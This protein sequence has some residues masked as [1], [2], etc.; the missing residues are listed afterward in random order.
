MNSES[1]KAR[2]HIT[3]S[4]AQYSRRRI[5]FRDDCNL[6][7]GRVVTVPVYENI[8][9][10]D[11]DHYSG[12]EGDCHIVG[13]QNL[14]RKCDSAS[15][16]PVSPFSCGICKESANEPI[17]SRCGHIFC[18]KCIDIK[19]RER[20]VCPVCES[21]FEK[22]RLKLN[23]RNC[24][25]DSTA[26]KKKRDYRHL[27]GEFN[28]SVA[29]LQK[30]AIKFSK[31]LV[32]MGNSAMLYRKLVIGFVLGLAFLVLFYFG[33][34]PKIRMGEFIVDEFNFIKNYQFIELSEKP[35]ILDYKTIVEDKLPCTVGIGGYFKHGKNN[36]SLDD[37]KSIFTRFLNL[38]GL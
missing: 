25:I 38:F 23:N 28:K 24:V 32:D 11:G 37:E 8:R 9:N 29:Y 18:Q 13:R 30:H 14:D 33:I 20:P 15:P 1:E 7:G 6:E 35:V 36:C 31:T 19:L 21:S 5:S 27:K 4:G 26:D 17:T 10:A 2:T 22:I 3:H 34:I 12:Q 16:P